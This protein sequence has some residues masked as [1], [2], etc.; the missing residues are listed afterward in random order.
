MG[1]DLTKPSADSS[2]PQGQVENLAADPKNLYRMRAKQNAL[3]M[4][5]PLSGI[6]RYVPLISDID[7]STIMKRRHKAV[8]QIPKS[9]SALSIASTVSGSK[10]SKPIKRHASSTNDVVHSSI[11]QNAYLMEDLDSPTLLNELLGTG[12]SG[13]VRR[14]DF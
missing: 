12:E 13:R 7:Q 11:L 14:I 10:K 6:K 5:D 8:S 9:I 1:N 3:L 4:L 2:V